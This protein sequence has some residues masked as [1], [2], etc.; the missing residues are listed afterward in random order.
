VLGANSGTWQCDRCREIDRQLA[1]YRR[2]YEST[3]DETA[4]KLLGDVIE[5]LEAEKVALHP[6]KQKD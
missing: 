5:D 4:L 3:D 1:G 6:E 2:A